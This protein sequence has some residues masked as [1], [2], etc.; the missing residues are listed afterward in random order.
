MFSWTVLVDD[1]CVCG[2]FT[3][4]MAGGAIV[5]VDS[6]SVSFSCVWSKNML[7]ES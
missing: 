1:V 3:A 5:Y 7:G 6:V 2:G 4:S